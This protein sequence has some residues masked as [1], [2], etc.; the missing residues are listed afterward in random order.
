MKGFYKSVSLVMVLIMSILLM[1]SCT[2]H[3]SQ[4]PSKDNGYYIKVGDNELSGEYIGYFFYVAQLN[5]IKEAGM[6]LGDGGNSTQADVD[7]FWQTTEIDG[8]SAVDVARDLAADNAV[9]LTVQYLRA[10]DEGITLSDEEAKQ[11]S[12]QISDTAQANG[13]KDAFEQTLAD[14]GC[15]SKSYKQILTE[16]RYVEKLYEHYDQNGKLSVTDA[17]L[18]AFMASQGAQISSEQALDYA[19]KDKFNSMA[20]QW[21]KD[22]EISISENKMKELKVKKD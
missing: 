1:C 2:G 11:I 7:T 9:M 13:G 4:T 3:P 10:T 16:N 14:M 12:Q 20:E 18:D 6:V 22:Y 5:M 17:E 15:D 21:K 8:K 19:K